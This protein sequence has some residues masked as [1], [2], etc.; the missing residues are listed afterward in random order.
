MGVDYVKLDGKKYRVKVETTK[1]GITS[2]YIPRVNYSGA[3]TEQDLAPPFSRWD[4]DDWS[5]GLNLH[6]APRLGT[7][8]F[9][10]GYGLDIDRANELRR[11]KA[12]AP[13]GT[14]PGAGWVLF[15][16]RGT[17]YAFSSTNA[18]I[19][20]S[21][22]GAFAAWQTTTKTGISSATVAD[23]L[24]Y[25]GSASDGQVFSWDGTTWA[26]RG[27]AITQ[28][29]AIRALAY[30]NSV[31]YVF[32]EGTG[33][34]AGRA[35]AG[36]WDGTTWTQKW[37]GDG[38]VTAAISHGT[39]LEWSV[40]YTTNGNQGFHF[41]Y[42]GTTVTNP[43]YWPD[44]YPTSLAD[45][46][47]T[48]VFGMHTLGSIWTWDGTGYKEVLRLDEPKRPYTTPIQAIGRISKWLALSYLNDEDGAGLLQYDGTRFGPGPSS[49]ATS[50]TGVTGITLFN[51]LAW[52]ATTGPSNTTVWALT[53][54]YRATVRLT[55]AR[56]DCE[57]PGTTKEWGRLTVSF[58]PLVSGESVQVDVDYD[59]AGAWPTLGTFNTVGA[60]SAVFTF[61]ATAASRSVRYRAWLNGPAGSAGTAIRS[62]VID[63]EPSP[64]MKERFSFTL[65]LED[66]VEYSDGTAD[67]RTAV[68]QYQDLL[69][70]RRTPKRFLMEWPDRISSTL[71]TWP[72]HSSVG[73]MGVPTGGGWSARWEGGIGDAD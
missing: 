72:D 15:R 14:L 32:G 18:T 60:T 52:W 46:G 58:D 70:L 71:V 67:T 23:T 6:R 61:P 17:V 3:D 45:Y 41:H 73:M 48:L 34:T 19:Y 57:L 51:G 63:Y 55:S 16:W 5:A 33:A 20:T 66:L 35:L 59:D 24:V 10:T 64:T 11:A 36:T 38:V 47:G 44:L 26:T 42:D 40:K 37:L 1:R 31:L 8:G 12:A 28:L 50:D 39:V 22:G 13:V 68:Q 4:Q 62:V 69:T 56:I 9:W 43:G 7:A 53:A 25:F 21:T 49:G 30:L 27:A 29:S 65:N 2:N 54:S